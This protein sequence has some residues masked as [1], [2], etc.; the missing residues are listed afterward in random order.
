MSEKENTKQRGYRRS[1]SRFSESS[2]CSEG[3][4]L[5]TRAAC[6]AA[7]GMLLRASKEAKG[8]EDA[9]S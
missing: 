3:R 9:T 4:M 2:D 1:G 5:L 8:A 7:L 6:G